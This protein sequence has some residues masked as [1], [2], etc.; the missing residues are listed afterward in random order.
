MLLGN[1]GVLVLPQ[2]QTV[3]VAYNAFNEDGSLSEERKQKAVLAL[4]AQLAHTAG[5]LGP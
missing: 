5:K 1:I 4:G 2:Q 3:P